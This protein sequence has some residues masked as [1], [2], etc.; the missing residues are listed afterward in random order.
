MS[1]FFDKIA[2]PTQEARIRNAAPTGPTSNPNARQEAA[3]EVSDLGGAI[4]SL[5]GITASVGE[6]VTKTDENNLRRLDSKYGLK[7]E[8]LTRSTGSRA[9]EFYTKKAKD[10]GKNSFADL[11][12]EEM[13][14]VRGEFKREFIEATGVSGEEFMPLLDR[15]LEE[16][17]MAFVDIQ[18]KRNFEKKQK[19]SYNE[20][21]K[22]AFGLFKS[23][24]NT[25]DLEADA[26]KMT[27][28]FDGL[29]EKHVGFGQNE[30]GD[31]YTIQDSRENAKAQLVQPMIREAVMK[32][33]TKMLKFLRSKAMRE[34]FSSVENYE[35]VLNV[36]TQQEFSI[37]SSNQRMNFKLLKEDVGN[38]IAT[39]AL[40][41]PKDVK[42][43]IKQLHD[44]QDDDFKTP[45]AD[46]MKYQNT[47]LGEAN[48]LQSFDTILDQVKKGDGNA[49]MN[50]DL[51][52]D[53]EDDLL[54]YHTNK[55]VRF[56]D[57]KTNTIINTIK[58]GD[59]DDS[60]GALGDSGVDYGPSLINT[61]ETLPIPEQGESMLQ[62][63]ARQ[64]SA[65]EIMVSET[66]DTLNPFNQHISMKAQARMRHF[67]KIHDQV[68]SGALDAQ[69]ANELIN[70]YSLRQKRNTSSMG[71]YTS[72]EGL[73]IYNEKYKE[74]AEEEGRDAPWTW[75]DN[76]KHQYKTEEIKE[77]F[78]FM[79]EAGFE[80]EEA[81]KKAVENFKI[82]NK[83][84][85]NPDDTE[86]F[87]PYAFRKFSMADF[88]EM[89]KEH[90]EIKKR[91]QVG[92]RFAKMWDHGTDITDNLGFHVTNNYGATKEMEIYFNK[93]PIGGTKFTARE[94]QDMLSTLRA[95]RKAQIEAEDKQKRID[96]K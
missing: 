44:A 54:D 17:S 63:V 65:Y 81:Y 72:P 87:I 51:K 36:T 67:S 82:T 35:N 6:I 1:K 62:A 66:Q 88:I 23:F 10:L 19:D 21:G 79:L 24:K 41:T 52:K 53:D 3:S 50:A 60:L 18:G 61:F 80:P 45:L 93:V 20:M 78:M 68:E 49:I 2:T 96:R 86:T 58:S 27:K 34:Y 26:T 32:G 13:E 42:S 70:S 31:D 7:V 55:I 74:K 40:K 64:S 91:I 11:T 76:L 46:L 43:Y 48:K 56:P 25:K 39:R 47:I 90:P 71:R 5:L 95:N 30:F 59:I 28:M 84:V 69:Q 75:Q 92:G 89:A 94:M 22:T 85:E 83:E 57:L 12:R 8:E 38:M 77:N 37:R 15:R 29:I 14:K 9:K 4:N 33:D 73:S 16:Q